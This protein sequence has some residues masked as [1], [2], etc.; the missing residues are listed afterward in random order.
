MLEPHVVDI[1][2]KRISL[3]VFL[4]WCVFIATVH[5]FT[6]PDHF[7]T[8]GAAQN[9]EKLTA[10]VMFY[11]LINNI[12]PRIIF[13][14]PH[15][16]Q[17]LKKRS[18]SGVLMLALTVQICAALSN[19]LM[20]WLP[21][22]TYIDSMTNGKVYLVRWCEWIPLAF[23]MAF[24]TDAID[25][26]NLR[27]SLT[28]GA[29]QSLST[30]G[31]ILLPFC[32]S[33]G[34]WCAVLTASL[35]LFWNITF[36]VKEKVV[37][38][39]TIVR[40]TTV[41]DIENY[42]RVQLSAR[43]IVVAFCTWN[44]LV[45]NYFVSW[46][47]TSYLQIEDTSITAI[48]ESLVDLIA[49]HFYLSIALQA[50]DKVFNES[51]RAERRLN[52]LRNTMGIIWRTSSDI[53]IIS[54]KSMDGNTIRTQ[55]SPAIYKLLQESK[56]TENSDNK[57]VEKFAPEMLVIEQ[58]LL[59]SGSAGEKKES[60]E[61][62]NQNSDLYITS[63]NDIKKFIAK[64]WDLKKTLPEGESKGLLSH[65]IR[66]DEK[67]KEKTTDHTLYIEGNITFVNDDSFVVI[68][69]NVTERVKRF[70][71]EKKIVQEHTARKKDNEINRFIRHEV[72]NGLL[73]AI[74]L[75]DDLRENIIEGAGSVEEK[76]I[77]NV[78]LDE[79]DT[80]L[81]QTLN[82][83]STQA[84]ARDLINGVYAPRHEVIDIR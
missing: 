83:V 33:P 10:M 68:A 77:H 84:M 67:K 37:R 16:Q 14:S 19:G 59:S 2:S 66:R 45:I 34:W 52:E 47:L 54:N 38:S 28:F 21:T 7:K 61:E 48:T 65:E 79:I 72:K 58:T 31:G 56:E 75:C 26:P 6:P 55:L 17:H 43:L 4:T 57:E 3:G 32:P 64:G 30:V 29:T 71:A 8:V 15:Q 50:H 13:Y 40:G 70:E 82:I 5:K 18:I 62:E 51:A 49:K 39:R 53:L 42:E 1:V 78:K 22:P 80:N 36:R 60:S 41:E 44:L 74:G 9:F 23:A 27:R 12:L 69:R 46:Y 35:A 20:A 81:N 11:S 73:A 24:L 76:Q 25:S 63:L